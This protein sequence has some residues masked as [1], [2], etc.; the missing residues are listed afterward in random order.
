MLSSLDKKKSKVADQKSGSDDAT[1]KSWTETFTESETDGGASLPHAH[2]RRVILKADML[3]VDDMQI[4]DRQRD[5]GTT[6]HLSILPDIQG[7]A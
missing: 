7:W 5:R 2:L 1:G 3:L 6:F 4:L